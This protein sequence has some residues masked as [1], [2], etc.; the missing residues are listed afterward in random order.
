M[1]GLQPPTSNI[2]WHRRSRSSLPRK[3]GS[4]SKMPPSLPRCHP[5]CMR[6]RQGR[7]S[8]RQAVAGNWAA[9]AGAGA[10]GWEAVAQAA[11]LGREL[12]H[13]Q[14]GNMHAHNCIPRALQA[15]AC[16]QPPPHPF[17][18]DVVQ[19][20]LQYIPVSDRAL[21]NRV[22][23]A[24]ACCCCCSIGCA[25]LD[26]TVGSGRV[27]HCGLGC[28]DLEVAVASMRSSG[29]GCLAVQQSHATGCNAT[30]GSRLGKVA[31]QQLTT[32]GSLSLGKGSALP[33]RRKRLPKSH[34]TTSMAAQ[35]QPQC[36][37]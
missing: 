36:G 6:G 34:T 16:T 1:Q 3:F 20:T 33:A 7:G 9:G 12:Q 5:I 30:A 28:S 14:V 19:A 24:A 37:A 8:V 13:C 29:I 21:H 22:H 32:H 15:R 25:R 27:S 18:Q 4:A 35:R 2:N 31:A 26:A 17:V 10:G 11:R 23:D